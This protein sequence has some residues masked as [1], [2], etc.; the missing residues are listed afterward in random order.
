MILLYLLVRLGLQNPGKR[1]IGCLVVFLVGIPVGI[2]DLQGVTF[3]NPTMGGI[4]TV[5]PTIPELSMIAAV[6]F[7]MF[8]DLL[9]QFLSTRE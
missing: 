9:W 6:F 5:Y 1:I 7:L 4:Q 8:V 3:Y 2:I